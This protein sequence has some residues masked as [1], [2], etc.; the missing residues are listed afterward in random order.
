MSFP[1]GELRRYLPENIDYHLDE[2][3]LRGLTRYYFFASQLGLIPEKIRPIELAVQRA[4]RVLSRVVAD[5]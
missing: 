5:R 4:E 1:A 3:N 2:E